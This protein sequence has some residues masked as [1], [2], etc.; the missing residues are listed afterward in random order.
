MAMLNNQRVKGKQQKQN[1]HDPWASNDPQPE[2]SGRLYP[3]FT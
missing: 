2:C 1:V 3:L